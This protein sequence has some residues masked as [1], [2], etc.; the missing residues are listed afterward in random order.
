LVVVEDRL[1]H[2]RHLGE[3]EVVGV[4]P[5]RLVDG[6]DLGPKGGELGSGLYPQPV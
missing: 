5:S 2:W 6:V 1:G 3:V 4:D